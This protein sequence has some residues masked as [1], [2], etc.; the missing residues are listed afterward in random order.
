MTV[1]IGHKRLMKEEWYPQV[2]SMEHSMTFSLER[3]SNNSTIYPI[4]M[5]DEALSPSG[6]NT[7]PEH[8]GFVER[9]Y[10][11]CCPESR[12][13]N[14][15]GRLRIALTKGA[16]ETDKVQPVKVGVMFIKTAFTEKLDATNELDSA[17]VKGTLEL[18]YETTDRQTYPIWSGTKVAELYSNSALLG[19]AVPGLTTTQVIESVAFDVNQYYDMLHYKTNRGALKECQRGLKWYTLTRNRPY[20]DIPIKI[21]GAIK[22]MNPY[23]FFGCL[24][25]VPQVGTFTQDIAAGDTTAI[26]HVV[27]KFSIRYNEWNQDMNHSRT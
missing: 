13:N 12:V 24:I 26:E 17:T 15:N 20:V 8:S 21:D 27:A 22:R 25:H 19:S 7:H 14:I 4:I 3:S 9:S 18:Q 6:Q 23:T 10:P 11:N 1:G 5:Q 2:H 16:L